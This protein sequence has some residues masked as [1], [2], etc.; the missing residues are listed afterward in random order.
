MDCSNRV[1][2]LQ[3]LEH[4]ENMGNI[5]SQDNEIANIIFEETLTD[6]WKQVDHIIKGA[7]KLIPHAKKTYIW[8]LKSMKSIILFTEKELKKKQ[9]PKSFTLFLK[10]LTSREDF[11]ANMRV[12]K[13]LLDDEKRCLRA[14]KKI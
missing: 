13:W 10:K 2:I 11:S 9:T 14:F 7:K 1:S 6:T 8:N 4:L 3:A 5:L 12:M